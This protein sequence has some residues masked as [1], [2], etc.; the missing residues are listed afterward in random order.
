[1]ESKK[2]SGGSFEGTLLKGR[3]R[4]GAKLGAGAFG[5]V[6][7]GTDQKTEK[8]LAIKREPVTAVPPQLRYEAK[9]YSVVGDGVGF[10]RVHWFGKRTEEH[11]LVMERLG[12]SLK[13]LQ[14]A[15][16]GQVS[17]K[18]AAMVG[19]QALRRLEQLHSRHFLHRDVKPANLAMGAG[20]EK[21]LVCLIDFGLAK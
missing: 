15:G 4:V 14:E 2:K 1:M 11:V 9:V 6:Y 18:T 20:P 10:P 12:P 5:E 16:G 7:K 21:H 13:S 3:Y 19:E 17:A 8:E